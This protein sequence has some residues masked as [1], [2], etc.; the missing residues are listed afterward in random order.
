M[1]LSDAAIRKAK[2]DEK[3]RKL[4]DGGGSICLLIPGA[5]DI[6]EWITGTTGADRRWRLVS[7]RM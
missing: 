6:G 2:P 5:D 3:Q 7:T 1:P 4:A